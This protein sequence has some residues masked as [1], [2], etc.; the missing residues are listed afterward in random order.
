MS[1]KNLRILTDSRGFAHLAIILVV[2]AVGGVGGFA[3]WRI[4][5]YNN[6]D[7]ANGRTTNN[8][9]SESTNSATL[10]DECVAQTGDE[11]ICRLGAISDLSQYSSEVKMTMQGAD[12][13]MTYT[14][15]YDGKG[16]HYVD[17]GGGNMGMSV[18][19]K[20]YIYMM[21]KWYD[22]GNDSSQV[23][24]SSV[25]SFGFATTAG[26]TYENQGK[27]PCGDDTC[28]KYKMSGGILADG[29]VTATFGDKDFLPRRIDSTGGLLGN[30]SM[31]VDYKDV[32]IT[33]PEGALPISSLTSGFG[34]E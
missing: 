32:T 4:S 8:D 15:K 6:N 10:S 20:Y 19:G 26:I 14:I 34:T 7:G 24:K 33:A 21:D 17:I 13:P 5:S 29:V 23:P 1:H 31:V 28:F 25:P 18:G 12:G 9:G 2:L 30:L 22:S 16:N 11:N 3:Y 27:E